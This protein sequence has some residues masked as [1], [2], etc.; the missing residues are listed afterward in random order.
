[1]QLNKRKEQRSAVVNIILS[2]S[3]TAGCSCRVLEVG[4]AHETSTAKRYASAEKTVI[5][6]K[7]QKYVP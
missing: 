2:L 7:L 6:L 5:K 4:H 3:F 1:M